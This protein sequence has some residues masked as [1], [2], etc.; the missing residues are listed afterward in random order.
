MY[1]T[2]GRG[3][4]RFISKEIQE[5][6]GVKEKNIL[7]RDGKVFFELPEVDYQV[8]Q[9]LMLKCAERVFVAIKDYDNKSFLANKRCFLDKLM[10]E[11]TLSI[12]YTFAQ[13][14]LQQLYCC[15]FC[16]QRKEVEE[17]APKSEIEVG[18]NVIKRCSTDGSDFEVKL[19]KMRKVSSSHCTD[20]VGDGNDC[21]SLDVSNDLPLTKSSGQREHDASSIRK[22][23]CASNVDSELSP[24]V[25]QEGACVL[26]RVCDDDELNADSLRDALQCGKC[27]G[28]ID[29]DSDGGD[30]TFRMSIKCSGKVRRWMDI[31]RL[32]R[33]LAWRVSKA[34][35]WSSRLKNPA[36]EVCVHISDDHMTAGVPL[37]K[38]PLSKR[39]YITDPGLR[40]P[41]AWIMC[42]LAEVKGSHC[43]LDP[44]CGK[45]TLLLEACSEVKEAEYFGTDFDSTQLTTA[46][47][48]VKKAGF[49]NNIE[50]LS[51]NS[52]K[53]PFRHEVFDVVLCD[54]PFDQK[55]S[56]SGDADVFY[57][58]FLSEICRVL[59][60][61]GRCVLLTSQAL[62]DK[63][64]SFMARDQDISKEDCHLSEFSRPP[65]HD[66]TLGNQCVQLWLVSEHYVKLG[67]THACIMVLN[68]L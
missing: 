24:T 11:L 45:G 61:K 57:F 31:A 39:S 30:L 13:K 66:A 56:I 14:V 52:H 37:T 63:V 59:R 5:R 9:L 20:L 68:K 46:A 53:L 12:N 44:M 64:Q 32:S 49:V 60:H 51:A 65:E 25:V 29:G 50:L 27:L 2:G 26:N 18:L 3:T 6:L 55:H 28:K 10:Q 48:N 62:K 21:E 47:I 42:H 16:G 17:N 8:N 58:K 40:A 19:K 23:E 54:A 34:S 22:N 43:V 41:V 38:L 15:Q 35:G 7:V 67:E 33:D 1:A 4:E 36:V